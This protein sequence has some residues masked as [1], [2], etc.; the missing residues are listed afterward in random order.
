[1]KHA[2]IPV[3]LL[4]LA[5]ISFGCKDDVNT[6]SCNPSFQD[7]YCVRYSGTYCAD[8]WQQNATT[9]EDRLAEANE[10]LQNEGIF[11]QDFR[12]A[13]DQMPQACLACQCLDGTTYYGIIGPTGLN[14]LL[15]LGFEQY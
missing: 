3:A 6:G 8:P 10:Y 2:L 1:M 13:H 11:I 12:I 5:V 9:D 7:E 15:D 14:K 4:C